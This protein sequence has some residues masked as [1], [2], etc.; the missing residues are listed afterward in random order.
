MAHLT[1]TEKQVV[2]QLREDRV[3]TAADLA[4]RVN[5]SIKTVR[6]ALA[7]AVYYSSINANSTYVTLQET[8]RFDQH[9][10]WL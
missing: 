7:K 9:G 6:R 3:A 1:G 2:K 5:V 8:P 4:K 10:L